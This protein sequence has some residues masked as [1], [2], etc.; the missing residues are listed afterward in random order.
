[1]HKDNTM[2]QI[3]QGLARMAILT[4]LKNLFLCGRQNKQ[5]V[6]LWMEIDS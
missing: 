1:M 3:K 5:T 6:V 2:N 4:I